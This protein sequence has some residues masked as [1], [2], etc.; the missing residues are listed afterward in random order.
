[1]KQVLERRRGEILVRHHKRDRLFWCLFAY[2]SELH[3]LTSGLG[4]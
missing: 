3:F 1:M 2:G 4:E